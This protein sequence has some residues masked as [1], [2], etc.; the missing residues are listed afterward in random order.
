MSEAFVGAQFTSGIRTTGIRLTATTIR[1][2]FP[3]MC[4]ESIFT[5]TH[6][7]LYFIDVVGSPAVRPVPTMSFPGFTH[8]RVSAFDPSIR[9]SYSHFEKYDMNSEKVQ[10]PESAEFEYGRE[11]SAGGGRAGPTE[12]HRALTVAFSFLSV[13]ATVQCPQ[14]G[15]Q[16]YPACGRVRHLELEGYDSV[17]VSMILSSIS[18]PLQSL[19]ITTGQPVEPGILTGS[20]CTRTLRVF[21][22]PISW[23]PTLRGAYR[24]VGRRIR[25]VDYKYSLDP[26]DN[27]CCSHI[28]WF[29][30]RF[31]RGTNEPWATGQRNPPTKDSGDTWCTSRLFSICGIR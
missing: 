22:A 12:P 19:A 20:P 8:L 3:N 4:T 7:F 5:S 6:R 14:R 21:A 15:S 23:Y 31:H 28:A 17:F 27:S 1:M 13:N 24:H 9:P 26:R 29:G 2:Q 30:S 10:H 25:V 16:D 18:Q 11:I